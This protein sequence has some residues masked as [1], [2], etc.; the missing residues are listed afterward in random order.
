MND[1]DLSSIVK[2]N[3]D[4][5]F[6]YPG[7]IPASEDFTGQQW[8]FPMFGHRFNNYSLRHFKI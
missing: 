7:G 8:D 4:I 5:L 2:D 1:L 3:Y 6:K